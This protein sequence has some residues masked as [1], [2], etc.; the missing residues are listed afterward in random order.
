MKVVFNKPRAVFAAV[1]LAFA[2]AEM[3][4]ASCVTEISKI[5]R[6]DQGRVKDS[7]GRIIAGAQVT[8]ASSSEDEIFQTKSGHDGLF[9]LALSS[10]KYRVEVE[11]EGYLRFVYIVD[12][13]SAVAAEPLDVTLQGA[14]DCHDI[15]VTSEQ[16]TGAYCGSEVVLPNLIL[17]SSSAHNNQR[18]GER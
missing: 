2:T 15:G 9:R 13:R 8:V 4:A 10:G 6:S 18:Q 17:H 5:V 11:A 1:C 7:G 12:L 14:S 16:D 3:S